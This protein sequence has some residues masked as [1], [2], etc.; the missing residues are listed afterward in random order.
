MIKFEVPGR[1]RGK[2]RVANSGKPGKAGTH[3]FAAPDSAEE[4]R[5]IAYLCRRAMAAQG[6]PKIVGPVKLTIWAVFRIPKDPKRR[7][8]IE[9]QG[10][11]YTGK[12]DADNIAKLVM[13][14]LKEVAWT[15]DAQVA[16]V[17]V[18]RRYGSPER[19]EIRVEQ[20]QFAV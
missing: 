10:N 16:I 11:W 5:G 15:D 3:R 18:A 12:P 9:D 19:I 20:P 13:D 14:A 6:Q 4:E 1:P 17:T 2:E 7:L 8:E